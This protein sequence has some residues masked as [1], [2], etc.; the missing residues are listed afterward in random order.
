[1]K[2]FVE[3]HLVLP[4]LSFFLLNTFMYSTYTF[5]ALFLKKKW[6]INDSQYGFSIFL[7]GFGFIGSMFWGLVAERYYKPSY[8]ILLGATLY[9]ISNLLLLVPNGSWKDEPFIVPFFSFLNLGTRG[10]WYICFLTVCGN[11]SSSALYPLVDG[12]ILRIL[13]HDTRFSKQMY[14]RQRLFGVVGQNFVTVLSG[15]FSDAFGF[16]GIFLIMA[17]FYILFSSNI[18]YMIIAYPYINV[19]PVIDVKYSDESNGSSDDGSASD[20]SSSNYNYSI[21][22][23]SSNISTNNMNNI[24]NNMK[25]SEDDSKNILPLRAALKSLLTCYDYLF[26]MVM[27]WITGTTRAVIGNFSAQYL[28]KIFKCENSTLGWCYVSRLLSEVIL[29]F[30]SNSLIEIYGVHNILIA[31][32]ITGVLRVYFYAS[33]PPDKRWLFAVSLIELFKGIN[34]AFVVTGSVHYIK[35]ISPHGTLYVA[36]GCY[37]GIYTYLSNSTSG[38]FGGL[39]LGGNTEDFKKLFFMTTYISLS[40]AIAFL[41][42]CII[43]A[44][45]RD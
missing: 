42:R 32:F 20:I 18:I 22:S 28:V 27:I 7:S 24:K 29:F 45:R 23:T 8:F 44:R 40:G 17:I 25:T 15:Y 34:S 35:E 16:Q 3:R 11:F 30:F 14:G 5:I 37:N 13:S 4:K 9:L 39:M 19:K 41:L 36:L 33:L 2:N 10:V 31:G 43:Q 1:M 6:S 38:I 26:F 12:I 21:T